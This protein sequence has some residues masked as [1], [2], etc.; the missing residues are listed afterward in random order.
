MSGLHPALF[1][2]GIALLCLVV[3]AVY[4]LTHARRR[5]RTQAGIS[6]LAE[7]KWREF[8]HLVLEALRRDGYVEEDIERQ[9]GDSG[10]DFVL[11]RNGERFLLSC[12]HGR[13][14]RL[15]ESSV[16]DFATAVRMHSAGGGIIATL[17]SIE[18]FAREIASANQIEVLDGGQLWERVQQFMP[19]RV[20]QQIDQQ[21]GRESKRRLGLAGAASLTL[22]AVVF[23]ALANQVGTPPTG[24]P[25]VAA[26]APAGTPVGSPA[27]QPP[28]PTQSAP[29]PAATPEANGPDTSLDA[30]EGVDSEG[31]DQRRRAAALG[32]ATLPGFAS[33]AWSTRSTLV[34]ELAENDT[35][36]ENIDPLVAE[37]CRLLTQHEDLRFTRVQLEPPPG[38]DSPVRWRQCR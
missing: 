18:G 7:L 24:S 15:G 22:G 17:G 26:R 16:R 37:A 5:A 2:I 31:V 14:F 34:L 33:A 6:A 1:A 28:V 4:L 27:A 13:T 20:V 32:L 21:V 35:S 29:T 3:A 38:V 30:G 36:N 23:V 11:A 19:E 25:A 8:A 10:F 12:K 9:P